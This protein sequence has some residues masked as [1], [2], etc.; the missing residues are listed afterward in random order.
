MTERDRATIDVDLVAIELEI[1]DE[2]FGDHRKGLVDLEQIDI[3]ERQAGLRQHLARGRHRRVQHQRR[4]VPHI[5]HRDHA[6]ARLQSMLLR[7]VGRRQKD[8]RR[9]IDHAGR[10]AGVMHEV[11]VEVGIFVQDQFA[12]GRALVV[13]RVVRDCGECGL[14][15][16]KTFHRGLRPRIFFAVERKAAVLAMNGNEALAEMAALDG[17][18]RSLLAFQSELVDVLPRNAFEGCDRVGANALVRLRM[19]GTQ[20]QVAGIHHERPLAA[21]AFHRHHLGAA[22]DHEVLGTGHDGIGRHIDAGDA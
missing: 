2:F 7:I 16:R 10:V 9:T 8:R 6:G 21:T 17:G 3:V 22:G 13:E 12:V 4:R 15:T 18:S 11:D 1:A 20:A 19:P 5:R 14:E